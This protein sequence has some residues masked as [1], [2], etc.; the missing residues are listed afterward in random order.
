MTFYWV[1]SLL[2]SFPV[3]ILLHHLL[4]EASG[5]VGRFVRK[6]ERCAKL[7]DKAK[8]KG[9]R[10]GWSGYVLL[11]VVLL[12][13]FSLTA[14]LLVSAIQMGQATVQLPNGESVTLG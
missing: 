5:P 9:P 2:C 12:A 11:A 6:N 13:L 8:E 3:L 10:E 7:L 4:S 14:F 1:V